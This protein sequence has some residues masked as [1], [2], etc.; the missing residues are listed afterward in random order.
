MRSPLAQDALLSLLLPLWQVAI[1]AV[2]L[3]V[4]VVAGRRLALRGPSRMTTA[5]VI[6][7]SAI[8]GLAAL[9][10]LCDA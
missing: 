6:T 5:L 8:V 9:T 7:G 10:M 4:I 1:G 3:V 2:V